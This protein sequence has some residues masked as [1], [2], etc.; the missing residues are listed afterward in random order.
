[1]KTGGYNP[2]GGLDKSLNLHIR[3]K[4]AISLNTKCHPLIPTCLTDVNERTTIMWPLSRLIWVSS[5][6]VTLKWYQ[7]SLNVK[8]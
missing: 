5:C 1:M 3:T 8:L 2:P 6:Q 7:W 4:T